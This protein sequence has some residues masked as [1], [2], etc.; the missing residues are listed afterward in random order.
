[1]NIYYTIS[2]KKARG[3]HQN[4]SKNR[5]SL[6]EYVKNRRTAPLVEAPTPQNC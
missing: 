5:Q 6:V 3:F 2:R 1:M 4:R